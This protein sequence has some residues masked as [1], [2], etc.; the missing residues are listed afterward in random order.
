MSLVYFSNEECDVQNRLRVRIRNC[1]INNEAEIQL[2]KDSIGI[3]PKIGDLLGPLPFEQKYA[4]YDAKLL[5][6]VKAP[7]PVAKDLIDITF[8]IDDAVKVNEQ[9]VIVPRKEQPTYSSED[10]V[11]TQKKVPEEELMPMPRALIEVS[12]KSPKIEMNVPGFASLPEYPGP[13]DY[14]YKPNRREYTLDG[15]VAMTD[16]ATL[17]TQFY[18]PN[19]DMFNEFQ[20]DSRMTY[21]ATAPPGQLDYEKPKVIQPKKKS[22]L[23][24]K[25]PEVS[26][27]TQAKKELNNIKNTGM[28]DVIGELKQKLKKRKPVEGS[29]RQ[30]KT[31]KAAGILDKVLAK[32]IPQTSQV[33][34]SD[35]YKNLLKKEIKEQT[36]GKRISEISPMKVNKIIDTANVKYKEGVRVTKKKEDSMP[37]TRSINSAP[38]E[39]IKIPSQVSAGKSKLAKFAMKKKSKK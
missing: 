34:K 36:K 11:V 31:R 4:T 15:A 28:D 29:G 33:S 23:S 27:L 3:Q 9:P 2:F 21:D 13:T 8:P 6:P 12:N 16:N 30:K 17:P 37:A 5:T 38:T 19:P 1:V 14:E 20:T 25:S 22:P 32:I 26:P 10:I 18:D 7:L 24:Q 39:K 35:S